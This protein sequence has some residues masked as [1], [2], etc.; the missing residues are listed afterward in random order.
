MSRA[1]R[2]GVRCDAAGHKHKKKNK[3]NKERKEV[4]CKR[5]TDKK[6][7]I[8]VFLNAKRNRNVNQCGTVMPL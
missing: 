5:E 4:F 2:N 3:K 6:K 8:C 7:K 1:E